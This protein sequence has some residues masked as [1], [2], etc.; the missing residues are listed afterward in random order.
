MYAQHLTL[1][2]VT[3][4]SHATTA[5]RSLSHVQA[6]LLCQQLLQVWNAHVTFWRFRDYLNAHTSA[7]LHLWH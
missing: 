5:C 4:E 7:L 1:S 3:L 2:R 6:H